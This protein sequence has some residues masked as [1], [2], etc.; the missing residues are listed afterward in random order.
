MFYFS[1]DKQ[2]NLATA[3]I[4][5]PYEGY[6]KFIETYIIISTT[7]SQNIG[8]NWQFYINSSI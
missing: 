8:I 4:K 7:N 1:A 6:P 3:L 5:M 2:L